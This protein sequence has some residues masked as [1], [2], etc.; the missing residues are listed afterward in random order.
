MSITSKLAT[1]TL[2]IGMIAGASAAEGFDPSK[3][4]LKELKNG[5]Y[6]YSQFFYN[7]L[8]VVTDEG[9]IITDPSG[10]ARSA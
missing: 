10:D 9:V 8:V 5:V 7:S 4:V 3:P 1:L 6:Q 2:T